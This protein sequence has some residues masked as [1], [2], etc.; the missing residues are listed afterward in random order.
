[1]D[2]SS[3]H[4]PVKDVRSQINEAS[5]MSACLRQII[6]ANEYM[7]KDS[8]VRIYKTSWGR[9]RKRY[10]YAHVRRMEEGRLPRIALEGK[11]IGKRAPGRPPPRN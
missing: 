8:K 1:M 4:N 11:P 10:W 6:W 3:Y 2:L 9:Q 5:V 7:R